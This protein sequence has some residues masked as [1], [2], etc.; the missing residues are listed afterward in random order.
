MQSVAL[1]THILAEGF[2]QISI[3]PWYAAEVLHTD[4]HPVTDAR[5]AVQYNLYFCCFIKESCR[6]HWLVSPEDP[7]FFL[8][9]ANGTSGQEG[10]SWY[11]YENGVGLPGPLYGSRRPS[12]PTD[13]TEPLPWRGRAVHSAHLC[14]AKTQGSHLHTR[15]AV[16]VWPR[17]VKLFYGHG[18]SD[19]MQFLHV[20]K[21]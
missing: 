13:N 3:V 18:N 6:W 20:T 2:L 16:W 12:G 1:A 8:G 15:A 7:A 19:S 5:F 11:C 4:V 21:C 9:W 10:H 14:G 17:S